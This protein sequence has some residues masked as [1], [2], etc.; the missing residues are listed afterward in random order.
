[1]D[2]NRLLWLGGML[3]SLLVFAVKVGLGLGC[4][5]FTV[6]GIGLTLS[7]HTALFLTLAQAAEWLRELTTLL[8]Q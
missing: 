4:G 5:N 8:L 6:K 2:L 3:F 1:M 7:G